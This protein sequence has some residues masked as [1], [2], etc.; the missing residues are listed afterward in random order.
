MGAGW[1]QNSLPAATATG[2]DAA[3][4]EVL[5][6]TGVPSASVAVVEGGK[7]A[8]VK[9][10]GKARLEPVMLAEPGMQYSIGSVSKQFT[11]A[12]ILLLVQDGKVKLD[13]PLGRYL[14]ELTRAKDVT[15]RQVLSMTSGYQDF[16]PE[17]Y[18]MTSM[19]QPATPQHILEVW[20]KKPLDFEPGT[21]WQYS[22]TNYVIAGR[23]AEVV[24]GKPLIEQLQE[25][26]FRPLK[27][28][29]VLNSDASRL[30]SND[31]TGY[32]QHAL[33]P[34]RP[35]PQEG[36]GWMFAAGELAMP[37]SDLALWNISLMNRT[38]LAPASYDEMFT[39]V[40]LKD[41]SG[42]H[43]GLGV[44]VGEREGHRIVSHSG[45]VSGFVSQ[46][47]VFPDDKVA[48]TVL[49]NEDASSAAAALARKIA[50]LVLG[51]SASANAADSAA[52][53]EKRALDIFTGL[54]DG[55]L[56]RSQLTAFCDAYFTAE[57][58][59]DFA[60]SLKPLGVPNSFKQADEELRGGMTFRVFDV[61]FPD[62]KLRV[63]T[64]EEP[65]GKLEQYL[66][67]PSGS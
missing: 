23:I 24:A 3:A 17:D 30:P 36:A 7:I 9:A 62:R 14:P 52:G 54:Q 2:I 1:A 56:D 33:G 34:L 45:E 38:L 37:A 13:D 22:N 58:V 63:T 46:N 40:K 35:A 44:Q 4:A 25:R 67:I 15:V 64:Y 51:Q 27:M 18:V 6:A 43:Y 20:G 61:S 16:W 11:A 59:Q 65:D 55:K 31:P 66:V 47:T 32:Y 57:A 8:Y 29:G 21:K 49:T 41:G 39:E 28:T 12:V 26:I 60:S 53:A 42:T 10:Y 50:P 5:K 19:M 48:V